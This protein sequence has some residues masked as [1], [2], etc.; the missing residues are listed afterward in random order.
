MPLDRRRS[1]PESMGYELRSF[2]DYAPRNP[3]SKSSPGI[4]RH[5]RFRFGSCGA[6]VSREDF[7]LK[8]GSECRISVVS[9]FAA[10]AREV[11]GFV[12]A[13]SAARVRASV[14]HSR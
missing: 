6:R 10:P 7:V 14:N 9:N 5:A 8:R 1:D 12:Q 13:R 11:I 3:V 2:S 4:D